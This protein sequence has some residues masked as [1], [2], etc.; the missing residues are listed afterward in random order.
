MKVYLL[1][2]WES[3]NGC[4]N[5]EVTGSYGSVMTGEGGISSLYAWMKRKKLRM[6]VVSM[7]YLNAIFKGAGHEV[8]YG[9]YLP[10]DSFDLVLMPTSIVGAVEERE[11]AAAIKKQ[12]PTTL[13]GFF[14]A[15]AKVD[16]ENFLQFGDFVISGEPEDWAQKYASDSSNS[17]RGVIVS[18]K[19]RDLDTLPDPD[20][21]GFP[22]HSYSYSP[23]LRSNPFLPLT[24]ARG[25]PFDC[26]YCPYMVDQGKQYRQHSVQRVIGQIKN[27]IEHHQVTSILFRDIVFSMHKKRTKE[28][29]EAIIEAD[30]G[31]RWG[32]ETRIDSLD[33]DL[34]RLMHKSGCE[35]MHFGV[36]SSDNA[37]LGE[38]G[39][40][41]MKLDK[42]MQIVNLCESLGMKTVCFYI[43]G[44]VSDTETSMQ[45]TI[46]YACQ[47]NSSMAQFGIMT[48]YPGTRLYE[49]LEDRVTTKDWTKYTTYTPVVNLDHLS[50]QQVLAAK[51]RAYRQYFMRPS[52]I[53]SRLPKLLF[54]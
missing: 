4:N 26:Y 32:C 16:A 14:G 19:I 30:L 36:E 1:D 33:E 7:A 31:I 38:A 45:D 11:A 15:F 52:W 21:R 12:S 20:Y 24:T 41:G 17:P 27:M 6:P 23:L 13:I 35:V 10:K 8:V 43:F 46:D 51:R 22:V 39:R 48:P 25:C 53:I 44:F 29:C 5:K 42:Q 3:P 50:A 54:K 18:E 49:Q 28:L 9:E 37:I 2:L 40:K 34:V 47:L